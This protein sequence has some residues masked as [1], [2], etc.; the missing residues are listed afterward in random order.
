MLEKHS[1]FAAYST[2]PM[3]S[4]VRFNSE[5]ERCTE[6]DRNAVAQVVIQFW[7]GPAVDIEIASPYNPMTVV[8]FTVKDWQGEGRDDDQ[9]L[10][11][12][13]ELIRR[14]W[15]ASLA[16]KDGV[17]LPDAKKEIVA[18]VLASHWAKEPQE[19]TTK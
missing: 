11:L 14:L 19:S 13:G 17:L 5:G 16:A 15:A 4:I 6:D 7:G 8:K 18:A 10:S 2:P 3:P 1:D 9:R 12:L